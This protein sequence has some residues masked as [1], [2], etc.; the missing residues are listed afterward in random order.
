MKISWQKAF[1]WQLPKCPLLNGPDRGSLWNT[2]TA[3]QKHSSFL[4]PGLQELPQQCHYSFINLWL[5]MDYFISSAWPVI[6][7]LCLF[8]LAIKRR[9]RRPWN[10][11]SV[12]VV[13]NI[14]S[15]YSP[16]FSVVMCPFFHFLHLL[17]CP[18]ALYPKPLA[19][20][21]RPDNLT[22][23]F[24]QRRSVILILQQ[25]QPCLWA[26]GHCSVL[27]SYLPCSSCTG[28]MAWGTYLALHPATH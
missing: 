9:N 19:F 24:S 20:L 21:S 7:R 13:H 28:P 4:S 14:F 8:P 27:H 26:L 2:L 16:F 12:T 22:H 17:S 11:S 3:V 6:S 15:S 10:S 5:Q 1:L 25:R 18:D 23:L